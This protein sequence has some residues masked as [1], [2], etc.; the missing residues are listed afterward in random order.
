MANTDMY[1]DF[2]LK[3][4]ISPYGVYKNISPLWG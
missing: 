2:K 4:T 1:D 3:E